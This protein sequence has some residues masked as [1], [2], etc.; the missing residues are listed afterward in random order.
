MLEGRGDEQKFMQNVIAHYSKFKFAVVYENH[1]I[2]GYV[3][4]KLMLAR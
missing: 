3:T 2:D 4:E 1:L